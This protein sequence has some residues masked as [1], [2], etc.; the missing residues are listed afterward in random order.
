MEQ[1]RQAGQTK[2]EEYR[3]ED[4][5]ADPQ[6]VIQKRRAGLS[7]RHAVDCGEGAPCQIA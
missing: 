5:H 6:E 3:G 7:G 1:R 4:R 2:N